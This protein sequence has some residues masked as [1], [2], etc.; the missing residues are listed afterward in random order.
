MEVKKATENAPGLFEE[1]SNLIL[2]YIRH[3]TGAA[4]EW[5][6]M[7]CARLACHECA[8]RTAHK[9]QSMHTTE[10]NMQGFIA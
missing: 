5:A 3:A 6:D 4:C 1:V 10:C 8:A 7:L 9:K 2:D